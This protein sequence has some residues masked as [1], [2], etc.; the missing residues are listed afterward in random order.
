MKLWNDLKN[1]WPWVRRTHLNEATR[2][3]KLCDGEIDRLKRERDKAK[4]QLGKVNMVQLRAH[5]LDLENK[6]LRRLKKLREGAA[7]S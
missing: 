1:Y 6:K 7:K 3:L 2:Q 4:T 5:I